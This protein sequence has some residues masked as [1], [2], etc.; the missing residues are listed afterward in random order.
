MSPHSNTQVASAVTA[1]ITILISLAYIVGLYFLYR[2]AKKHPKALNRAS[3]VYL[4]RYAPAVYVFLIF[5][6]IVEIAVAAWLLVVFR[7][8][9]GYPNAGTR[10]GICLC[11]FTGCWTLICSSVYLLLFVHKTLSKHPI[12]SIGAQGIW[13]LVTWSLWVACAATLDGSLPVATSGI[14]VGVVFCGQLQT[15]FGFAIIEMMT[16][17]FSMLVLGWL[18]WGRAREVFD[19]PLPR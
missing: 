16:F 7:N 11:L 19:T 14:C 9:A 12:I 6:S 1:V 8:S 18:I 17:T 5:S 13:A 10:N 15:L 4:Q 3:S 2:Y